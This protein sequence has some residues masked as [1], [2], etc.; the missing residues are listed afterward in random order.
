NH[1]TYR[2]NLAMFTDYAGDFATAERQVR[3]MEEPSARAVLALAFSQSGQGLVKDAAETYGRLAT[4]GAFGATY[5]PSGLGDLAL[6][7]GRYADAARILHEAAAVDVAAKKTDSA[8]NKFV[9]LSYVHLMRGQKRAAAAAAE[10]ALANSEAL[11]FR[12]L[13]ARILVETGDV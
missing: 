11:P 4:M 9:S 8:A 3:A 7:E 1:A 2:A 5:A 10:E 6:Y 13:A 12:F